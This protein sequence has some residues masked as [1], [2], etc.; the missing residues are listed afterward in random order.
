[1]GPPDNASGRSGGS[2]A[3]IFSKFR[4]AERR[5]SVAISSGKRD[6]GTKSRHATGFSVF[7]VRGPAST[8]GNSPGASRRT[9]RPADSCLALAPYSAN[10][11]YRLRFQPVDA[12][13]QRAGPNQPFSIAAYLRLFFGSR[14]RIGHGRFAARLVLALFATQYVAAPAPAATSKILLPRLRAI[15]PTLD[16]VCQNTSSLTTVGPPQNNRRTTRER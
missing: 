1:M 5:L 15:S 12:K 10:L 11:R 4:S 9:G 14:G 7:L 3:E 6:T 8:V 13:R 2:Y 16:R